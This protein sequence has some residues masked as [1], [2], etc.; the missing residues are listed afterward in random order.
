MGEIQQDD[1]DRMF[2][3]HKGQTCIVD[4]NTLCQEGYCSGCEIARR[5]RED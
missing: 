4:K 3:N 1:I 5:E 2:N